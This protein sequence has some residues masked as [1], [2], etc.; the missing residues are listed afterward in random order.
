MRTDIDYQRIMGKVREVGTLFLSDFRKKAIPQTTDSFMA[1]LASIETRSLDALQERINP[2]AS[3]IAWV[4]DNEF[5]G[6]SQRTPAPMAQYW[7]C[8][9]MDGAVQYIQHLAGWTINLVLIQQ[10]RPHFAV[11]Y[12]PLQDELFWALEGQG[13]YLGQTKLQLNRKTDPLHMLAVWE[14]GHQLKTDAHWQTKSE[15]AF[16]ALLGAFGVVRN[17][18]PHGLQLAYVGAGRID[19]FL[20]MDLDTHNW[21]AGLLIAQEAGA[22]ILSSDGKPWTWG[23]PGLLVGT[24]PAV[25][26]FLTATNPQL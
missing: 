4:D 6:E 20:Q 11:V 13:A 2:I 12:D 9:T 5:D 15:K 26:T 8:D 19:L 23:T 1:D 7:L 18:G 10:G 3:G 21:L 22:L 25:N 17:Y 16:S 24:S 14:Y